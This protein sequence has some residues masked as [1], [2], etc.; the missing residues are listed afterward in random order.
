MTFVKIHI[1]ATGSLSDLLIRNM[2]VLLLMEF[3]AAKTVSLCALVPKL[4]D[5]HDCRKLSN[6]LWR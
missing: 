1:T 2:I 6:K 4:Q 3:N 5:V